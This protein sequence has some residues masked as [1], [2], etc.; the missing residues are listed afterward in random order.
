[1]E[2]S[3]LR[4]QPAHEKRSSWMKQIRLLKLKYP[5]Y[6]FWTSTIEEPEG[7]LLPENSIILDYGDFWYSSVGFCFPSYSATLSAQ[8][9]E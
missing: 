1:M 4:K 8:N 9:V 2:K 7:C 3:D 6:V 5:S